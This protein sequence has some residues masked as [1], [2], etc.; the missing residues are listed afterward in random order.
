ML[1]LLTQA[2]LVTFYTGLYKGKVIRFDPILDLDCS[3]IT[4]H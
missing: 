4:N 2:R 1:G 3:S